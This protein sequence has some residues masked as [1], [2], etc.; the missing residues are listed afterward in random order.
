MPM[1]I[2]VVKTKDNE[3]TTD[4]VK[5]FWKG[6]QRHRITRPNEDGIALARMNIYT[7]D[8]T[9]LPVSDKIRILPFFSQPETD[10]ITD[11]AYRKLDLFDTEKFGIGTKTI[12]LDPRLI[13]RDFCANCIATGVPDAGTTNETAYTF[14]PEETATIAENMTVFTQQAPNWWSD[15]TEYHHSYLGFS[16]G[17][18]DWLREEFLKDPEG[19]QSQYPGEEGFQQWLESFPTEKITP[20]PLATGVVSPYYL[21]DSVKNT[22]LNDTFE[23]VVRP[24]FTGNWTGLGGDEESLLYEFDHEYRTVSKQVSYVFLDNA[25]TTDPHEDEWVDLWVL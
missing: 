10:K 14:T 8:P 19:I 9:G 21:N 1:E 6:V 3:V 25:Y 4:Q 7:D 22:L 12:I 18:W 24:T 11:P 15:A 2:I 23:E 17:G 13:C 20:L 16:Q 5:E